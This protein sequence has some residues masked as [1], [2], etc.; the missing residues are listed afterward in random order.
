MHLRRLAPTLQVPI[1]VLAREQD[2]LS[3]L[4]RDLIDRLRGACEAS[5]AA[6]HA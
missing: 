3:A 6:L 2:P 1:S 4:H 5:Q